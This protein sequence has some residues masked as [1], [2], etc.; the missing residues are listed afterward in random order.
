MKN[1]KVDII[2]VYPGGSLLPLYD[3]LHES[4]I[5]HI[6]VRNEQAAPHY[7]S[8]YARQSGKKN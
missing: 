8:G 4:P 2:F 1:E 3:A 7:A 6:L 5:E